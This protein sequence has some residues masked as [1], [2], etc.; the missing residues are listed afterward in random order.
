MMCVVFRIQCS[1]RQGE[2]GVFLTEF[3][4]IT[5]WVTFLKL[6]EGDRPFYK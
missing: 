1:W 4:T 3:L 2:L 5:F 6:D